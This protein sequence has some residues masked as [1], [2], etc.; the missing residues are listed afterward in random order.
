MSKASSSGGGPGS[1]ATAARTPVRLRR[2]NARRLSGAFGCHAARQPVK[3]VDD[4]SLTAGG[5]NRASLAV[6]HSLLTAVWHML[7]TG[8]T[9]LDP[10]GDYYTRRDPERTTRRL[11]AQLQRLGHTVTLTEGAAG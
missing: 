3:C 4:M 5:A 1:P 9:Y 10:G 2:S 11:V 7:Q 8:Q 6:A